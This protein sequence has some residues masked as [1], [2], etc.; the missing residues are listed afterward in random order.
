MAVP[1]GSV[2]GSFGI[3]GVCAW[4]EENTGFLQQAKQ[5]SAKTKMATI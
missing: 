5:V 3:K 1:E 2:K 4:I